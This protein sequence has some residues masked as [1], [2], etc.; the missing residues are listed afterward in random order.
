MQ[1]ER[2]LM[3]IMK[4]VIPWWKQPENTTRDKPNIIDIRDKTEDWHSIQ[5]SVKGDICALS[6]KFF[7]N[8]IAL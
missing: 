2:R 1:T 3:A 5:N 7:L 8:R 6:Q 4:W